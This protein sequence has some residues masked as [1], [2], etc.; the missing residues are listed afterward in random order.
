MKKTLR[1]VLFALCLALSSQ[2]LAAYGP[3]SLTIYNGSV[4]D[5]LDA[6]SNIS[7]RSI[8]TDGE[9]KG[10]IN[11]DIHEV[12]FDTAMRIICEAKGLA[13]RDMDGVVVVSPSGAGAKSSD[14]EIY[15]LNYLK[16]EDV[17]KMLT[18]LV[19]DGGKLAFDPSATVF[20]LAAAPLTAPRSQR[21]EGSGQGHPAGYLGS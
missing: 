10:T 16:A 11:V 5:V 15:K 17:Q 6:L 13:Y 18:G 12:D 2:C 4:Q 14:V 20:S 21:G 8:V 9:I 7:G 1:A 3:V 19:S